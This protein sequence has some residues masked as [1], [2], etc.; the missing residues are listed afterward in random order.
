MDDSDTSEQAPWCFVIAAIGEEG[1]DTRKRSDQILRHVI[2]RV[3]SELGYQA[4]RADQIAE[5][6]LISS[7]VIQ[8]V[9]EDPIVI[10]DLTEHNPNVFYELGLRHAVGKPV[11]QLI[12]TGEPLPFDVGPVRTIF[13]DHRNMDSVERCREELGAQVAAIKNGTAD[14]DT[15]ISMAIDLQELRRSGNPLEKS[16]AEILESL[17]ELRRMMSAAMR[18]MRNR[19]KEEVSEQL[20]LGALREAALSD[21]EENARHE[22]VLTGNAAARLI[23]ERR[24][25]RE[26]SVH[27]SG[28][29][30]APPERPT[31]PGGYDDEEPF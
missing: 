17:A 16:N 27:G 11:I 4:V 1:S 21:A 9:I 14:A 2:Q 23:S 15:P 3:V 7:Q 31:V 6:G 29:P 20:Y 12:E 24:A 19:V 22:R 5:P 28:I 8:H 18:G 10:A 30:S 13:I 25:A 26:R